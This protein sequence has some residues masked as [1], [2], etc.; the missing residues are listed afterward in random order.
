M[1][2]GVCKFVSDEGMETEDGS[3]MI[4]SN[5]SNEKKFEIAIFKSGRKLF[6]RK[7]V[8]PGEPVNFRVKPSL[9]FVQVSCV[10]LIL[11]TRLFQ[12]Y[13]TT[14]SIVFRLNFF[15]FFCAE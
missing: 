8:K 9:Y 10:K 13:K 2:I 5:P 11:R 14:D 1:I 3:V 7:N 15:F 6:S 4:Y 12:D